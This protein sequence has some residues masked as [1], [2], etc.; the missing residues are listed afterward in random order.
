MSTY[1]VT[2][3]EQWIQNFLLKEKCNSMQT[4]Y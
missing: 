1:T 3:V 4:L 2:S